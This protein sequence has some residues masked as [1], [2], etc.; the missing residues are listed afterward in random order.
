MLVSARIKRID[1]HGTEIFTSKYIEKVNKRSLLVRMSLP[2][3]GLFTHKNYFKT[4]GLFDEN[5]TFCMDYEHLLRSYKN[6]PKVYTSKVIAAKWRADGL[7]NGKIKE[8]YKE[9]DKIKRDNN[10]A[11]NMVLDLINY[12]N[13]LKHYMKKIIGSTKIL[14]Y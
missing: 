13:L 2:H 10:V 4:Y 3:Q 8:I 12:W 6:F 9:W 5:N 7:G 14:L 1:I 11:N